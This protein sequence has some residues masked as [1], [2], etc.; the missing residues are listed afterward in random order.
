MAKIDSSGVKPRDTTTTLLATHITTA[1]NAGSGISGFTAT[2]STDTV[3]ITV[4]AGQGIYP[5]ANYATALVAT[6][7]ND[8]SSPF[9]YTSAV[10]TN[11]VGSAVDV[12]YYHL[13]RY[14]TQSP[15]ATLYVGLYTIPTWTDYTFPEIPLMQTFATGAIRQLGIFVPTT[16]ETAQ[17]TAIQAQ[18]AT[19]I[20]NNSPLSAILGADFSAT[21]CSAL[22]DLST[23]DSEHVSVSAGQDGAAQGAQL[24]QALGYSITQVGDV[25][26]LVSSA[27]VSD[28]IAW[29]ATYTLSPD[30]IE[31]AVAAFATTVSGGGAVPELYNSLT[32]AT[33]DGVDAYRYIFGRQFIDNTPNG[34]YVND[35]HCAT[36]YTSD[37][38]YI[39]NNRTIDKASRQAYAAYIVQLNAPLVV[40]STGTLT[41]SSIAFFTGIGTQALANMAANNPNTNRP[42]ISGYSVTINPAQN[43]LSASKLEVAIAI[44]PVGVGREIIVN[45]SFTVSIQS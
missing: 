40:N 37:Y 43:V 9:T 5:N 39:E 16:F 44:V 36:A 10:T 42:E 29:V 6:V 33:I 32:E 1:I 30:G 21:T 19:L 25:L 8:G 13:N 23:L 24:F 17:V 35:S 15:N 12:I 18:I 3:L 14:F 2:S 38:A 20:S 45:M 4:K 27:Q 7:T 31:N 34:T 41:N 26:G 22:T 28:D 11:G